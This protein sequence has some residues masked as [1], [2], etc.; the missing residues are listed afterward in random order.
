MVCDICKQR[1]ATTYVK[2]VINGRLKEQNLCAHCAK[3]TGFS[4]MPE[5]FD[6]GGL[7]GGILSGQAPKASQKV[8]GKCG[9]SFAQIA[10]RG[11]I[12]CEECYAAFAQELAPMI[13]KI[14]GT[15]RHKGKQPNGNMLRVTPKE[16]TGIM[17]AAQ[18]PLE[19]KRRLLKNA[20]EKQEFENAA[21]LRDEIKELE[22][23]GNPDEVV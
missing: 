5:G 21:I 15:A 10:K 6:I 16:K 1:E 19:E 12:G 11:K 14:H 8:C 3:E 7:L 20:I 4:I 2:T 17:P 13:Q 22:K 9:T 23:H 18:T